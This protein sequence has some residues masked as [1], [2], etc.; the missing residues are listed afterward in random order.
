MKTTTV[1]LNKG[2]SSSG[3]KENLKRSKNHRNAA[4]HLL[5]AA[6]YHFEAAIHHEKGNYEKAEISTIAAHNQVTLSNETQ[7]LSK[8]HAIIGSSVSD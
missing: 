3:I 6:K 8:Q 1:N 4:A 2:K 7:K 5:T